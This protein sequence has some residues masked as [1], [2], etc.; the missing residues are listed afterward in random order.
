M[1]TYKSRYLINIQSS[2]SVQ[3]HQTLAL[4]NKRFGL[5][6]DSAAIIKKQPGLYEIHHT[7]T[8]TSLKDLLFT[9]Y[10]V[11]FN[12]MYTLKDLVP[13][14]EK[15]RQLCD[16]VP[17]QQTRSDLLSDQLAYEE[18]KNLPL[19]KIQLSVYSDGE[20]QNTSEIGAIAVKDLSWLDSVFSIPSVKSLLP[21]DMSLL[22]SVKQP[23]TDTTKEYNI[24]AIK[25]RGL[26]EPGK[27]HI[28]TAVQ[29]FDPYGR[30]V[31]SVELDNYGALAFEALTSRNIG[32]PIAIVSNREVISAPAANEKIVGGQLVISGN[33]SVEEAIKHAYKLKAGSLP[34]E[35]K[36]VRFEWEQVDKKLSSSTKIV[37]ISAFA[38]LLFGLASFFIFRLLKPSKTR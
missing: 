14:L 36:L 18:K 25:K 24:Y 5:L 7:T 30:P 17:N 15:I 34:S 38:F 11:S 33:F 3:E 26:W 29:T 6:G 1:P 2:T 35:I 32:K 8:D 12:E 21:S 37:L 16:T 23:Y 31:I 19:S 22:Y 9:S 20:L 27:D 10:D 28:K 4:L 13:S